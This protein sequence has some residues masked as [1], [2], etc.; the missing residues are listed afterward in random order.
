[1]IAEQVCQT[2]SA[3]FPDRR[4]PYLLTFNATLK[5]ETDFLYVEEE[6]FKELERLKTELVPEEELADVKSNRKYGFAQQLGTTDGVANSL[7]NYIGLTGDPSTVN[8]LFALYDSVTP[9]DIQ[10]MVIKYF[11]KTSS[12]VATLSGRRA[13]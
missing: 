12:T 2:L 7:V 1:V 10:E 3:S 6:I 5:N 11:T 13:Q 8:K 4:D 9:Q